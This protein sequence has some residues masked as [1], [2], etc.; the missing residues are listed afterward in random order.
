[1]F[2]AFAAAG[3]LA[4]PDRLPQRGSETGVGVGLGL[5][6]GDL[7]GDGFGVALGLATL[8]VAFDDG[9]TMIGCAAG[10]NAIGVEELHAATEPAMTTI[11][12]TARARVRVMGGTR[13]TL[14][15]R[16]AIR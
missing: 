14:T 15:A 5:G 12:A 1:V 9:V 11:T 8:G 10:W 7:L 13:S 16:V 4:L 3:M 6:F 2:T